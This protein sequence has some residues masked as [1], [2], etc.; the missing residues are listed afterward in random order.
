MGGSLNGQSTRISSLP[1]PGPTP[2]F[3]DPLDWGMGN[4]AEIA[5]SANPS[6]QKGGKG[7]R[8]RRN[9]LE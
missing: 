3:L 1:I 2:R 8:G 9:R 4:V 5:I 6:F 7:Q